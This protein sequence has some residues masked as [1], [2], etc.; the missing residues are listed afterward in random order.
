[1]KIA[2]ISS[3]KVSDPNEGNIDNKNLYNDKELFDDADLDWYA[4]GFRNYD[5]QI[6]RFTQLDPLTWDYPELT[7]YQYASDEPIANVDIDGLEAYTSVNFVAGVTKSGVQFAGTGQIADI[8]LKSTK[9]IQTG[10]TAAK[11]ASVAIK[12]ADIATDFIP[13]VSGAK[14]IYKGVRDG[15]WWQVGFG[16]LS[17]AADVFTLGGSSVAKG[18]V[19]TAV[20]ESAEIIAKDV[21]EQIV[22]EEVES[23]AKKEAKESGA[24]FIADEKGEIVDT[25]ATPQGSYEHPGGSRTDILQKTRHYN[26]ATKEDVGYSHTHEP[27]QHV[28]PKTG[29]KYSGADRIKAHKVTSKEIKNITSG[30]AKKIP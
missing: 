14:D 8:I 16:V 20:R 19:K 4:Y 25:K 10:I 11:V 5:A 29:K 18:V 12:A 22:K 7:N 27:Y 17:I 21:G 24:R 23:V 13:V 2:A 28:N 15:N 1:M 9:T 6:G 3:T 26:K 30:A